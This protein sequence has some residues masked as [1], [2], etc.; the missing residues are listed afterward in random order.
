MTG[1]LEPGLEPG[2][3]TGP[4]HP[5]RS[6][7]FDMFA[8]VPGLADAEVLAM[9]PINGST[10]WAITFGRDLTETERSTAL[11]LM[12]S[13]GVDDMTERDHIRAAID[14]IAAQASTP[15]R[16]LLLLIARRLLND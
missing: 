16:R 1:D 6:V 10:E 14:T 8:D 13:T 7:S 11:N 3:A 2:R 9:T 15:E 5:R 4:V 12:A